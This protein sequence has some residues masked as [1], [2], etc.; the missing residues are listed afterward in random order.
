M[1]A[2]LKETNRTDWVE[3]E[4]ASLSALS[5]YH[6]PRNEF[7]SG[8]NS[9]GKTLYGEQVGQACPVAGDRGTET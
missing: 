6:Q 2:H 4:L 5:L 7:G 3:S 1:L 8:L 9:E